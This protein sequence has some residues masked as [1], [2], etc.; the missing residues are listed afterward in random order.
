MK[1]AFGTRA[2]LGVFVTVLAVFLAIFVRWRSAPSAPAAGLAAAAARRTG[3]ASD[4]EER[5][6]SGARPRRGN[7]KPA[8]A[9]DV[10]L[11]SR[12]DFDAPR[13]RGQG[14]DTRNI[15]DSRPPTPIPPPTPTPGLPPP[16]PPG[17]QVFV[18]P[19]PPPPP[20]PTPAPPEITFK[21]IG[22]FGPK[23]RPVAVLVLGDQ[24]VNARVGDVV[25]D[26]FQIRRV[27]YESIDVGFKDYFI[28]TETRRLGITP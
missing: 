1:P 7:E 2:Q 15:F 17:S 19:L 11:F 3:S 14:A 12:K 26:R 24:V 13:P 22:T 16:P 18:G 6:P 8:S 20:T 10:P 4:G 9:Q 23:D 21:F 28:P 27:G 5:A 25:F